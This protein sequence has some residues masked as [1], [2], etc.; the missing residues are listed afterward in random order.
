[1]KVLYCPISIVYWSESWHECNVTPIIN[2]GFFFISKNCSK[3]FSSKSQI[4]INERLCVEYSHK[5]QGSQIQN[6]FV[7]K[8]K[9]EKQNI[10]YFHGKIWKCILDSALLWFWPWQCIIANRTSRVS[11]TIKNVSCQINLVPR[12]SSEE[13]VGPQ[14]DAGLPRC[15]V[16]DK[17]GFHSWLWQCLK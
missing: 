2:A 16:D 5:P 8:D 9:S 4:H 14:Q 7:I 10:L 11:G 13:S 12:V 15:V 17:W 1:M 6:I 3:Y